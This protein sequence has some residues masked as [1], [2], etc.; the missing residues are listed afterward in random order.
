MD[1]S[2]YINFWDQTIESL[3]AN[4]SVKSLP[5]NL[6]IKIQ[7]DYMPEPYMGDPNNCSFVIVNLNPGTGVCHSCFKQQD[8]NG[9]LINKAKTLGYSTAVKDYPY[10]QEGKVVGLDNWDDSPGRKWWKS[11]EWWIKHMLNVCD[12]SYDPKRPIPDGYYPFAMELFAWHTKSW[13]GALNSKMMK[14]GIFGTE[15]FNDVIEPLH[16]AI[17]NSKFKFAFCVGKPIG[18]IIGSFNVFSKINDDPVQPI[19]DTQRFYDIYHDG[20]SCYFLNTWA[21]GGNTYPSDKFSEKEKEFV[22]SFK[23]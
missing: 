16:E 10:L 6:G 22:K 8:I 15:I 4:S 20:E 5:L 9:T 19:K 14:S 11:K 3:F 13:P 7:E 23:K 2:S 17:N 18:S 21:Q 12:N 1:L